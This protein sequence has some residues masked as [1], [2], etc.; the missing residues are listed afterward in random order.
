ML[1]ILLICSSACSAVPDTSGDP[2]PDSLQSPL[3]PSSSKLWRTPYKGSV[4]ELSVCFENAA[5]FSN[6]TAWVRDAVQRSWAAHSG[7][8]FTGFG[9]CGSANIR[10]RIQDG[11][12]HTDAL[13]IDYGKVY[14]NFTYNNFDPGC[15]ANTAKLEL[16]IRS[17][18]VHEFGHALGFA[19]EHNHPDST[20]DEDA[21]RNGDVLF[22]YDP[23]SV[24][25]Y[26][27]PLTANLSAGDIEG[28]KRVYGFVP[29]T[30]PNNYGLQHAS[31]HLGF[32]PAT[33]HAVARIEFS[34]NLDVFE[35]Y[36]AGGAPVTYGG[37]VA[38]R[39]GLAHLRV[40]PP[41][42]GTQELKLSIG[43]SLFLWRVEPAVRSYYGP[44]VD[45]REPVTLSATVSGLK[46]Y[47]A[48]R[49]NRGVREIYLATG[50]SID[51][52]W[53]F[54]GPINKN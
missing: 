19:H 29:V 4:T 52:E 8:D 41:F 48:A 28:V 33:S 20:C 12:P 5:G 26:C 7:V 14:L 10:V 36:N 2:E 27:G 24:M 15:K 49:D 6:E 1:P 3:F 50:T 9:A 17:A 47:L 43:N 39:K 16:C 45:T 40:D 51:T 22:R 42:P 31:G 38:L 21:G 11:R 34:R 18:A 44:T 23:N 46:R 54:L 13:G 32:Y 35:V 25:N 30:T 37:Q 53:R